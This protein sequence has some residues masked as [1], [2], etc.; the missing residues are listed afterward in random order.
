MN[1]FGIPILRMLEQENH[2]DDE[3]SEREDS[4]TPAEVCSCLGKTRVPRD[5]SRMLMLLWLSNC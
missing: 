5:S 3:D 2:Q 4:R 1:R